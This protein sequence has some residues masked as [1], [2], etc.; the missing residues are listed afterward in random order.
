MSVLF[1]DYETRSTVNLKLVG[2][3][4]YAAHPSTRVLCAAYAIDEG[5]VLI[6]TPGDPV[7]PEF[8]AAATDPDWTVSAFNDAFERVI[9]EHILALRYGFPV[10]PVDRHRC[11]M[12]AARA[13]ALPGSLGGVA[14][15]LGLEQ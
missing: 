1:R 12:A 7:P 10:I 9:E 2:A 6:W 13:L 5:P 11:T 3:H 15:A 8:T 14:H 4:K